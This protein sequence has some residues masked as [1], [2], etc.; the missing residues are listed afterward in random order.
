MK[1]VLCVLALGA[2]LAH[3]QGQT[4]PAARDL[5]A[6]SRDVLAALQ[7]VKNH[8]SSLLKEL[9]KQQPDRAAVR[10]QAAEGVA[11]ARQI[12][13]LIEE[14]DAFYS[15]MPEA[16]QSALRRS[17]SVATILNGCMESVVDAMAGSSPDALGEARTG[18]ECAE[19]RASQMEEV[20]APFRQQR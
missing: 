5:G 9:G 11:Q 14:L 20:L 19:R 4:Q 7:S 2:M 18:V 8:T 17:W 1:A 6:A 16:Q 15:R 12:R 3:A 13:R 10:A